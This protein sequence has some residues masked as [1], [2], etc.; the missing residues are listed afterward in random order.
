MGHYFLDIGS[1]E[2]MAPPTSR[3]Q[4]FYYKNRV[5]P[6]LFEGLGEI[7]SVKIQIIK[8]TVHRSATLNP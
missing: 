4:Q 3:I 2:E 5:R 6:D 7:K 1:L 8:N